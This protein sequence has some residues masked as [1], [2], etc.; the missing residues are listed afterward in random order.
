M[1]LSVYI[2]SLLL[3]ASALFS[4]H[5]SIFKEY[6]IRGVVGEE[7][8]V[9]ETYDIAAAIATYYQEKDTSVKT[10]ALGADGRVHS[11]LIRKQVTQALRDFGFDVLDIGTCT[12]PVMYF[13]LHTLPVDAGLM[14]TASHNPGEYNGIKICLG[15]SSVSGNEIRRIRDIYLNKTFSELPVQKGK[16]QEID[17]ISR[18]VDY[19]AAQFPHL[20]GADLKAIIDC[21]NG[22]AGSVMP[23][24]VEKMQWQ[25]VQLLYPELDGTYPH[26][27]ADPTVE[28]YM[29]DLKAALADSSADFGLGFDGDGDRMAPMTKK[30]L[31]IKG[32]QLLTLFSKPILDLHPGSAIVFDVSSSLFLHDLVR[33][34]GGVPVI[35]G[36]GV[37]CVKRVMA[38]T[39]AYV[40]GEISC[41][42]VFKDRYFGF[43]DGIYSMMRLFELLLTSK[44]SLEDWVTEFPTSVSSPTLRLPC[45]RSICFKIIEVLQ[46][47]FSQRDDVELITVDGLRLHFPYGWAIVRP[48]NTEPLISM[49]FEG[50]TEED[51]NK[52]KWEFYEII[53]TYIE[54]SALKPK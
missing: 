38:E 35:S 50:K 40:G 27:V 45:E 24:L 31:L 51:L 49:R 4:A 21:G 15:K 3:N 11:P 52:L 8:T 7:F 28:K 42:T 20:I 44:R 29:Q 6:D 53:S 32:D 9:E 25:S 36:T 39:G 54:C 16:H 41:H 5:P 37:A 12:T 18:Y 19:F 10:V 14:I 48:S 22:A 43:D 33:K 2:I 1:K 13:S 34:W 26:H 23:S 17:L 46:N 47:T 30:G